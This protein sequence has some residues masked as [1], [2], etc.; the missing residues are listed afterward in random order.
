MNRAFVSLLAISVF[1]AGC[2]TA[3]QAKPDISSPKTDKANALP[4]GLEV[5]AVYASTY[6][7]LPRKDFAITGAKGYD[8][9]GKEFQNLTLV[10]SNG[11]IKSV[12]EGGPVPSGVAV[13]DAGGR[14]LTPGIIDSHSHLG[15]YASP[16]NQ[17]SSDGNEATKPV[18]AEVW[19]EHSVWPQDPG[20]NTA[21]AGGVTTL[22]ILPGSANLIGGRSVTLKNVPSITMQ[23]MKF[24]DAPYGLKMACG[25]N[26]KRVYGRKSGP[27][28]RMGNVAGYRAAWIG[29]AA[30]KRDWDEYRK[31]LANGEKATAPKRDLN[32]ETLMGVLN[33]EILI[34]N[35]CYRADEMAIMIDIAKEFGYKIRTFHHGTE[36][37]KLAQTLAKEDICTAT[38][39]NWWGFKMESLDG[40]EENAPILEHLGACAVIHSDDAHLTQRLNLEAAHALMA[41]RRAGLELTKGQAMKWITHNAAKSIGIDHLTG[42][43]TEG[44]AADLVLWDKDPFSVYARTSQVFIDGALV[45]DRNDPRY[46]AV[47]DFELG[48]RAQ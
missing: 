14:Y 32:N 3:P 19:A 39:A 31:K 41:G 33:G 2:E 9:L 13:I 12:S 42:S 7:H 24:P 6:R 16:S 37:Y 40:I 18:T 20:F 43:I 22:M 11:K 1:A 29:A 28:T 47:S 46:Q 10:V 45:Y 35:H 34:Q 25:E 5:G 15:V 48:F 21:R 26:P 8:G 27:S 30:Y 36:A 17:A 4:K 44:K 38:W 23:G